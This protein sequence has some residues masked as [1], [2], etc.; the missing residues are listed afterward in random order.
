MKALL[1][2]Q[3]LFNPF[4]KKRGQ[5]QLPPPQFAL[6]RAR[7]HIN[8]PYI[9]FFSLILHSTVKYQPHNTNG[10]QFPIR[11]KTFGGFHFIFKQYSP[12]IWLELR[13]RSGLPDAFW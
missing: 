11:Q 2:Y 3:S 4:C 10:N 1:Q 13:W 8:L 5:L 12:R 9:S 7:I 6:T